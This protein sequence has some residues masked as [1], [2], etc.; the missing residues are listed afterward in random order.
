MA[1]SLMLFLFI[2]LTSFVMVVASNDINP[3]TSAKGRFQF[4]VEKAYSVRYL[5]PISAEASLTSRT[6]C[7]A[8]W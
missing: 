1:F 4:S 6:D 8:L 7:M 5:T 3:L 2:V